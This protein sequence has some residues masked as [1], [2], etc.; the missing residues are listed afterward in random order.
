MLRRAFLW[1]LELGR[2]L[3]RYPTLTVPRIARTATIPTTHM[4]AP[5]TATMARHG[6]AVASSSASDRGTG[7]AG[8]RTTIMATVTMATVTVITADTTEDPDMDMADIPP[9]MVAQAV[10]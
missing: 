9:L 3:R 1:G 5:L 8:I 6:L 2:L 7:T 10:P 4:P